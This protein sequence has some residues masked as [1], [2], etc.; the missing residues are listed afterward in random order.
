MFRMK[1]I[2]ESEG[3]LYLAS[4]LVVAVIY[5]LYFA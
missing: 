2:A 4:L 1:D 3:F 5:A